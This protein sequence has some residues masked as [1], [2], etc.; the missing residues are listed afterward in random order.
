MIECSVKRDD[1]VR[2]LLRY[3]LQPNAM[4]NVT[5]SV[6]ETASLLH[7]HNIVLAG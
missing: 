2:N 4:F 7:C 3:S 5:L 1:N 6:S